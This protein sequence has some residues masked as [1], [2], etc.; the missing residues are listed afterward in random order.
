MHS[1]SA[2]HVGPQVPPAQAPA[3]QFEGVVQVP[4]SGAP[5][6]ASGPQTPA[7]H[8]AGL[9]HGWPL[10]RLARQ[11]PDEQKV[12]LAHSALA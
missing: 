6:S 11:K 10:G 3:R 7:W 5:H 1:L 8:C 2:A 12:P 9:V 4:P